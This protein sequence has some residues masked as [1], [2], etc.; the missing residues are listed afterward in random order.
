MTF[1]PK[2]VLKENFQQNSLVKMNITKSSFLVGNL[3]TK[4][5]LLL[6][7]LFQ[8]ISILAIQVTDHSHYI[9]M[10]LCSGFSLSQI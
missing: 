3:V 2:F 10:Y 5:M 7:R 8:L 4:V 1:V 9:Y 6:F